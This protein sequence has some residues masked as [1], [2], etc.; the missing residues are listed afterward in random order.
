MQ[1]VTINFNYIQ[2]A[3][4]KPC[5]FQPGSTLS[6]YVPAAL[7]NIGTKLYAPIVTLSLKHFLLHDFGLRM[8]QKMIYMM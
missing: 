8:L 6:S 3:F 2:M 5:H 7:C 4:M 1:V